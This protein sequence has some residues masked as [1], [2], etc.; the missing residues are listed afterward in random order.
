PGAGP[1]Q[2]AH[3]GRDLRGDTALLPLSLRDRFRLRAV[4]RRPEHPYQAAVYRVEDDRGTHILKWYHRGHGPDR[5]VWELLRDR[6]RQHLTHFTETDETGADGHPYDLT[7]SYG[8]TDLAQYLRANPGPVDPGLIQRVVRQLHEALTTLHE[9][10][11]VHRDLSPANVVL[12]SL[13][14]DAP[15]APDLTLVDFAVSAYEPA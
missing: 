11:I 14:P 15:N 12:G 13:D 6:P 1:A 9:L 2:V 5:T 10:N 8:E 3:G 4:L 7:P